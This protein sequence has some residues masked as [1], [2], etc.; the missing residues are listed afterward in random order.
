M[1]CAISGAASRLSVGMSKKPWIWPECRS[2][3][4]TRS[5]PARVIRLATSLAEIGV[6]PAGLPVLPCVAEIG[7]HR[8][9][10]PRRRALQRVDA[11]Q[12]LHQ[13]VVRRVGGRLQ[14]E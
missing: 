7:H 8:G 5:A 10:P 3:V 13:V 9:D 4:S 1:S 11:D 6:A 2:I 12:E 14:D